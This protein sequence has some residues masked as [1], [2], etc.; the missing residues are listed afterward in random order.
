M[1]DEEGAVNELADASPADSEVF[2]PEYGAD[3][4]WVYSDGNECG[5]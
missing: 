2:V 1:F 5:D 4:D 3:E